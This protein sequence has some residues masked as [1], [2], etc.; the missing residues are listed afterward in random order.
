MCLSWSNQ[1]IR[2]FYDSLKDAPIYLKAACS[3]ECNERRLTVSAWIFIDWE[4][5]LAIDNM[6]PVNSRVWGPDLGFLQ[7]R[8]LHRTRLISNQIV[9]SRP[10]S[11]SALWFI[12]THFVMFSRRNKHIS[13]I[14]HF[15][16]DSSATIY[17]L[18]G[19]LSWGITH[20]EY[21]LA[22]K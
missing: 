20:R 22:L 5:C 9:S 16:V 14:K 15:M 17:S 18:H 6:V 2:L 12:L 19:Q 7:A 4:Q 3:H 8:C 21:S 1:K 10:S 11:V 13:S